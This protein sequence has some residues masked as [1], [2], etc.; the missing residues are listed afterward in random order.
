M[1]STDG[2][3]DKGPGNKDDYVHEKQANVEINQANSSKHLVSSVPL[4]DGNGDKVT[5][6]QDDQGKMKGN[7]QM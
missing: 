4:N 3:V 2:N 7:S 1:A 6:K 5:E